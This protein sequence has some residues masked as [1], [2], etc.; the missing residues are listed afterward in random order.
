MSPGG[1]KTAWQLRTSF[2]CIFTWSSHQLMHPVIYKSVKLHVVQKCQS[3]NRRRSSLQILL[4]QW[5][6][7]QSIY[8]NTNLVF[9]CLQ[10]SDRRSSYRNFFHVSTLSRISQLQA[11][12]L[13]TV[14]RVYVIKLHEQIS[15]NLFSRREPTKKL[16]WSEHCT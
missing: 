2:N 16:R 6:T 15:I 10:I 14:L 7:R 8:S 5:W 11:R 12:Q 3:K 1:S 9:E 13:C 4:F